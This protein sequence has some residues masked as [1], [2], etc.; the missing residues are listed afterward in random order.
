MAPPPSASTWARTEAMDRTPEPHVWLAV[1]P[2]RWTNGRR[3]TSW[4][5]W[6]NARRATRPTSEPRM[7]ALDRRRGRCS[8]WRTAPAVATASAQPSRSSPP[9]PTPRAARAPERGFGVCLDTAHLWGAGYELDGSQRPRRRPRTVDARLGPRRLRMLH[10]ND[11][12]V[13]ARSPRRP[14]PAHRGRRDRRARHARPAHPPKPG[15]RP[16]LP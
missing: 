6:R 16:R 5:R 11:S 8:C 15:P 9:S 3:W 13:A 1:W 12:K 4:R 7:A 2:R 10:L 14:S